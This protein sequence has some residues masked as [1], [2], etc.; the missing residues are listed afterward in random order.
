[1]KFQFFQ[2][3]N[4]NDEDYLNLLKDLRIKDREEYPCNKEGLGEMLTV[5]ATEHNLPI[6]VL[7]SKTEDGLINIG[8]ECKGK[9]FR[10]R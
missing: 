8:I 9:C 6:M 3:Y 7:P 5:I 10:Q 2:F 1:M 4:P